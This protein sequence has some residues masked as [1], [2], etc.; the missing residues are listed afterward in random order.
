MRLSV[1]IGK[2]SA[3]PADTAASK[4]RAGRSLVTTNTSSRLRAA[5]EPPICIQLACIMIF[6][7]P[8]IEGKDCPCDAPNR[9]KRLA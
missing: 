1:E 6:S 7:P 2:A 4:K 5:I 3:L 8:T 9:L